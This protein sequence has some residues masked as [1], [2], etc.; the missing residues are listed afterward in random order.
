MRVIAL[1][2]AAATLL[3]A[4]QT[5]PSVTVT[6]PDTFNVRYDDVQ[7][8]EEQAD[9]RARELC[10]GDITLIGTSSD[11]AGFNIRSYRCARSS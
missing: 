1:S 7:T 4:C 2:L 9:A 6:G 10:R 8:T 5:L 11:F 3:A